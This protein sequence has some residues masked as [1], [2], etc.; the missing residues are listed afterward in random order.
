MRK[1][2]ILARSDEKRPCGKTP[3]ETLILSSFHV[4][5]FRRNAMRK[6]ATRKDATRK[7]ENMTENVTCQKS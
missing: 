7:D 4:A 6:D 2:E 1:D 3:F 5:S